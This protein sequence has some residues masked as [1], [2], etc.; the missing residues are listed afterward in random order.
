MSARVSISCL[1]CS[2]GQVIS[3]VACPKPVAPRIAE[4]CNRCAAFPRG[5]RTRFGT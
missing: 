4:L 2:A 5:Y 1:A 3:L